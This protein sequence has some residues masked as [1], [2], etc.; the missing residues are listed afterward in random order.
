MTH[1]A[2]VAQ[3]PPQHWWVWALQQRSFQLSLAGWILIALAIPLL[4]GPSLPFDRPALA[5]QPVGT[6]ILNAHSL[7]VLALMVIAVANLV[8]PHRVVPDIAACS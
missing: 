2:T 6:Q 7:L 4:A 8:T 3:S 5:D 1:T